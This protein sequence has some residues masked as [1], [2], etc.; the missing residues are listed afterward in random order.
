VEDARQEEESEDKDDIDNYQLAEEES[1]S[2]TFSI[3]TQYL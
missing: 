1:A 2:G 3:G